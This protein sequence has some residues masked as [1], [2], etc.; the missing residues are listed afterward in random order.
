MI[1]F[2]T[3]LDFQCLCWQTAGVNF[4]SALSCISLAVDW[5]LRNTNTDFLYMKGRIEDLAS[6]ES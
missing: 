5:Y 1:C 3:G 2:H 4:L 6:L